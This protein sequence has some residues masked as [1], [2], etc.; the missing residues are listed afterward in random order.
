MQDEEGEGPEAVSRKV[1][2]ER[3]GDEAPEQEGEDGEVHAPPDLGPCPDE[4]GRADQ[5]ERKGHS[6]YEAPLVD[7]GY[8]GGSGQY[9]E[10]EEVRKSGHIPKIAKGRTHVKV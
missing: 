10:E 4:P 3:R 6:P 2:H 1:G 8:E 9:G 7:G 5:K